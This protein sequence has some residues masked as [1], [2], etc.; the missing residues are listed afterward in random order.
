MSLR[1]L[2]VKTFIVD[3]DTTL[4]TTRPE[5][6]WAYIAKRY[7]IRLLKRVQVRRDTEIDRHGFVD[8]QC[9]LELLDL[10]SQ[11]DRLVAPGRGRTRFPLF[12]AIV[13]IQ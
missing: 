13:T 11:E 7:S 2:F 5:R 10:E 4:Y 9:P 12:P 8:C 1:R 6:E 3:F